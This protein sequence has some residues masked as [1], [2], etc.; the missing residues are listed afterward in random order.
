[1]TKKVNAQGGGKSRRMTLLERKGCFRG[2]MENVVIERAQDVD[3]LVAAFELVHES[4]VD[5][6]LI[7]PQATGMRVRPFDAVASTAT[8]VARAGDQIVGAV[9]VVKDSQQLGLPSDERFARMLNPLRDESRVLC[10]ASAYAIA[11]PYRETALL[12]ELMRC[13]YA[14]AMAVGCTDLVAAVTPGHAAFYGVLGFE[15]LA[16]AD[17]FSAEIRAAVVLLRADLTVLTARVLEAQVDEDSDAGLLRQYYL[18][19][20]P[21]HDEV[22]DWQTNAASA[23]GHGAFLRELV[24]RTDLLGSCSNAD[25]AA[26]EAA[27]GEDLFLDVMGHHLLCGG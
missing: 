3:D 24:E 18:D 1:M 20:N 12:T 14:H 17:S 8:F 10:E 7:E 26:I 13:C 4:Y 27:W 11:R 6:G 5:T 15:P 22:G 19:Y 16:E 25:V 2:G 9:S 21:Y 23:Y